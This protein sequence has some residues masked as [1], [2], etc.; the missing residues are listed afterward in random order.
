MIV[1]IKKVILKDNISTITLFLDSLDVFMTLCKPEIPLI[2]WIGINKSFKL[3]SESDIGISNQYKINELSRVN[4]ILLDTEGLIYSDDFKHV[5]FM[6]L[7]NEDGEIT[8]N[9]Q[10]EDIL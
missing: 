10:V 6:P 8:F 2:L 5:G 7:K 4:R 9:S 1:F 3:L